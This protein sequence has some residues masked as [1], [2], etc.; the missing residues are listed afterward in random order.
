MQDYVVFLVPPDGKPPERIEISAADDADA[1]TRIRV[2][3]GGGVA[4]EIWQQTRLVA[5]IE[6]AH[7]AG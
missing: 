4:I 3:S 1:L 6:Q 7:G 5:R 2:R